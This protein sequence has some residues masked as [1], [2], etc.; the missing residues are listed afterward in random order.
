MADSVKLLDSYDQRPP[1]ATRL[2][3]RLGSVTRDGAKGI[4]HSAVGGAGFLFRT[5]ATA[6]V[7]PAPRRILVIRLDL[8]GDVVLTLSGVRALRRAFP[9]AEIDMLVLH[10]S[11]GIVTG[12]PEVSRVLTFD[13]YLWRR[14]GGLFSLASWREAWRFLHLLGERRYDVVISMSGDI[15]SVVARLSGAPRR[16]GYAA[17]AYPFMLT[18]PVPGGRYRKPQHEIRYVLDLAHAAGAPIDS[19][20]EQVALRVLPDAA[21]TVERLL[22]DGRRRLVRRG[23]VVTLHPGARNGQAKRWP[24]KHL[25]ALADRLAEEQGALVVLTGGPGEAPIAAEVVAAARC[26]LLNLCGK[27][28]LPELAA[29]LRQSDVVVS[30]DSG[31]MHI[32]CAVGARVVA[33]HGPTDPGQSGPTSPSAIVVRQPLWC[34]P[35]YDS[36]KTAECRFGNPVCMKDL[37]PDVVLMAVRRQL[38][39]GQERHDGRSRAHRTL[40]ERV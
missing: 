6:S 17:E 3:G 25:A 16:I 38:A 37:T 33:L 26:D 27:T 2:A 8:I 13:P 40:V 7:G 39:S 14:P 5:Q 18:H 28:S 34:S 9:D 1:F 12:Q 36:S 19:D 22:D 20:D 11:A 24:P 4:L 31:P 23:P 30:G 21:S 32:A 10:S 29:L 15:A 35:C